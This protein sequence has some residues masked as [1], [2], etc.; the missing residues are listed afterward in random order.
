MKPQMFACLLFAISI[1]CGRHSAVPVVGPPSPTPTVSPTAPP[2]PPSLPTP[3]PSVSSPSAPSTSGYGWLFGYFYSTG[4][5]GDHY[6]EQACYTNLYYA[7]EHG[8]G[9]S[10]ESDDVLIA[11]LVADVDR[12]ARNGKAIYFGLSLSEPL[13]RLLNAMAPYWS[14]VAF[15][16]IAGEPTWNAFEADQHASYWKARVSRHGLAAKPVG[17]TLTRNAILHGDAY[18]AAGLD[19]IGVEGYVDAP[20]GTAAQNRSNL[21]DFFAKANVAI[22]PD[23][24]LVFVVQSYDRNGAWKNIATL[25]ALQ[26]VAL[27]YAKSLPDPGRRVLGFTLFAYGRP[28]GVVDHTELRPIHRAMG[29]EILGVDCR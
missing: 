27:E 29:N 19:W 2:S 13:D 17:V 21:L 4:R 23:K 9:T 22:P 12:A 24:K 8:E 7:Y 10:A 5:Y 25:V 18:R 6:R 16:E 28:G 14:S 20:G 26:P 3:T 15:V 1:S 11:R